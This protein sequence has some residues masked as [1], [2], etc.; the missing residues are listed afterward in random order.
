MITGNEFVLLRTLRKFDQRALAKMLGK[1]QQ[2]I[3][4]LERL[5]D[6]KLPDYWV[7]KI[8]KALNCNEAVVCH[9]VGTNP[10]AQ[11][12]IKKTADMKIFN[13]ILLLDHSPP[14]CNFDL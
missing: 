8:L 10:N 12:V 2:Y 3:S 7:D 11:S 4:R 9:P 6:N 13:N 14:Y 5:G 1:S